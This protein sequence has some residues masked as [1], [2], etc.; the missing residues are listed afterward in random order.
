MQR[1]G[2]VVLD[3]R[4]KTWNFFWW[5]NGKRRSKKIGTVSQY[6]TKTSAWRAAKEFR[7]ALE[8]QVAPRTTAPT[9]SDLV[10]N[11]R[12]EKMPTRHDTRGGYES[13]LRVY[14]RPKWG[15]HTITDLQ[16]RPVETVV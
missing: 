1:Q 2:S 9:V 13:W 5:D 7:H 15:G 12:A 16:A 4:I 11:Y 14:I 8:D 3:K 10:E 6:P